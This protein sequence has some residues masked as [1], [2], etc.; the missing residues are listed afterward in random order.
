MKSLLLVLL[1][2]ACFGCVAT[3]EQTIALANASAGNAY[4]TYELNKGGTKAVVALTHLSLI[5][6]D[7]PLGKVSAS[8]LGAL[9]AEL[10]LAQ[11]S[12]VNDDAT[13]NQLGSFLALISQNAGMITG[14]NITAKQALVM[15]HFQNVSNG[16]T[17]A[18]AFW[19][20]Q[21]TVLNPSVKSVR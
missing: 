20:G 7:V 10:K 13:R 4:A 8:E 3:P 9:G 6:P 15:A 21:Q 18:I 16:I 1:A 5:L 11:A 14:G 17:N 12:F 2:F 19:Q